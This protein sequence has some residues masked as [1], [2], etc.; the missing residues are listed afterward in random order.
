MKSKLILIC[1]IGVIVLCFGLVGCSSGPMEVAVDGSYSGK[2]IDLGVGGVLLVTLDSNATTGFE[3]ELTKNSNKGVLETV[4]NK[5]EA[6]KETGMVG[7]PG[8]EVWNFNGLTKGKSTITMEYSQPWDGG[9]KAAEAFTL[10]VN[11]K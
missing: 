5:Y 4:G 1:T 2:T 6:P 10:T 7:A 9:T 3:W 11:V 8:K